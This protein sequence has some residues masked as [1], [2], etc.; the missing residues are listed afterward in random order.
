MLHCFLEV[1]RRVL[2]LLEAIELVSPSEDDRRYR[3]IGIEDG[4]LPIVAFHP[5][6]IRFLVLPATVSRS[7]FFDLSNVGDLSFRALRF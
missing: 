6:L 7:C 1:R 4:K 3:A 5:A 2:E